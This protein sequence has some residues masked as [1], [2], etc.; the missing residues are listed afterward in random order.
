MTFESGGLEKERCRI[1][2]KL[3]LVSL[4]LVGSCILSC[5]KG[6]ST[7]YVDVEYTEMLTS[8]WGPELKRTIPDDP[9][10]SVSVLQIFKAP[11]KQEA[12]FTVDEIRSQRLVF[13]TRK[14]D[15]ILPLFR[16]ARI[17]SPSECEHNE[18]ES[19]Y[20]ILAF[21]RELLRVAI[22]KY[23]PCKN[24]TLGYFQRWRSKSVYYSAELAKLMSKL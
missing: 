8:H 15:D 20:F 9:A 24:N 18:Y 1:L 19:V 5:T 22:I 11:K 6:D 7:W 23:F 3:K 10:R 12:I 16:A 13:E 2:K 14:Q 4:L 21:D 17:E